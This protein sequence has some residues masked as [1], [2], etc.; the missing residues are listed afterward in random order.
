MVEEVKEEDHKNDHT[1]TRR[2]LQR[3]RTS[4]NVGGTITP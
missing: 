2:P 1:P 4:K 3:Q